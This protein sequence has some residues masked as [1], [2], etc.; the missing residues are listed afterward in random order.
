MAA[1]YGE[2]EFAINLRRC[3]STTPPPRPIRPRR[4]TSGTD[5][6]GNPIVTTATPTID[7]LSEGSGFGNS[8]WVTIVDETPT[9]PNYGKIIG[10]FDPQT[11]ALGQSITPNSSNSTNAFGN[12]AIPVSAAFGSN[13]PKTIEI[14]T[15]DDTGAQS[16]KVTLQ[17]TLQ[18]T[19]IVVP[20]P[21]SPPP[22][23]T[24]SIAP[25]PLP[26]DSS[27][28]PVTNQTDLAFAGTTVLGTFITVTENWTTAPGGPQ[29]KTFQVPAADINSDG[30]FT[31][32]FQDFLDTNG[33]P[34]HYGTFT[35]S[36]TATYS[37]DSATMS[38]NPPRAPRLPSISTTRRPSR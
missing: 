13:G 17:F 8:T 30:S 36:A 23:P 24:R 27:G 4:G 37:V 15:T 31:F 20:P 6:N 1:T 2:G 32:N 5:A 12:F 16:T 7:G 34:L 3:S 25:P 18:A 19:N 10:G 22:A 14:Y 33:T 35:V 29:T 11:Y 26:T 9:D 38:A 21:T 28:N